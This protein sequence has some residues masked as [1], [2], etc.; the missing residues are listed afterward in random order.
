VRREDDHSVSELPEPAVTTPALPTVQAMGRV[1]ESSIVLDL[2]QPVQVV[3]FSDGGIGVYQ[4]GLNMAYWPAGEAT[5]GV[6]RRTTYIRSTPTWAIVLAVVG[7]FL[8]FV[9]SLL[10]L[11]V[12]ENRLV[13]HAVT[14]VTTAHGGRL[15]IAGSPSPVGS[16]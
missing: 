9:F 16:R 15:A 6:E 5:M 10:F 7:F 12:K 11:L 3:R 4:R 1:L 14:T 8:V 13:E 2:N